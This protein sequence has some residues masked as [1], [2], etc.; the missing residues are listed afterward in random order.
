M[1]EA[2]L[3]DGSML[4]IWLIY[5]E[6]NGTGDSADTLRIGADSIGSERVCLILGNRISYGYLDLMSNQTGNRMA[7]KVLVGASA[8]RI[9]QLTPPAGQRVIS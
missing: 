4:G 8:S 3:G 6:Q 2:L 1:F 5:T 7:V 9:V